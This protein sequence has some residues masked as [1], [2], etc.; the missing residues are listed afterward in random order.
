MPVC[1]ICTSWTPSSSWKGV[2]V[3]PFCFLLGCFLGIR[4]L[5]FSEFWHGTKNPYKIMHARFFGKTIFAPP[6]P[7]IGKMGQKEAKDIYFFNLKKNL[8]LN[9][10]RIL[11]YNENLYY[12]KYFQPLRLQDF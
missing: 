2:S 7:T 6:P 1:C 8:V 4:S 5:G 11:F 10:T 12:L 3:L 9:F